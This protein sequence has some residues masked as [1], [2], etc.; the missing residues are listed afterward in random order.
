MNIS[1]AMATYNG[2]KYLQ[3]QLDSFLFQTRQPNELVVCDDVSTDATLEIL[4]SFQK[5]A[6]FTVRIYRNEINLAYV[7]NFEKALSLCNGDIIFLSDQ[8]DVWFSNKIAEIL[9]IMTARDNIMVLQANMVLTN[10]ALKPTPFTQLGNIL[11][12]GQQQETFAFGCATALRREWLTIA[13]PIPAELCGH[14]NWIHRLAV[15]LDVRILLEQPLQYYR[16]HGDNTSDWH[17]S[18][19]LKITILDAFLAHGFLDA[20]IGWRQELDR[21]KATW[22][23]LNESASTLRDLGLADRRLNAMA[24]LGNQIEHVNDRIQ[25]MAIP[26]VKRL[27]RVLSLWRRGGYRQFA[28]WKSAVKDIVRP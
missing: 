3:E 27:P 20:T 10:E 8:D 12:A 28:D 17:V 26:R 2:A 16:R 15:S 23:R 21:I 9:D 14:D 25:N 6:P 18:R 13:L 11:S 5:Q 4:E 7:K 1:I 24:A 22:L 19:P